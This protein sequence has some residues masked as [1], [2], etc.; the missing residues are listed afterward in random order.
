MNKRIKELAEQAGLHASGPEMDY[1]RPE[2]Y[3]GAWS[4][5]LEELARLVILDFAQKCS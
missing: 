3:W 5:E 2:I 4:N 1:D